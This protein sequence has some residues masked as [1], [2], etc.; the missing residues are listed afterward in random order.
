[1]INIIVGLIIIIFIYIYFIKNLISGKTKNDSDNFFNLPSSIKKSI[2]IF[3]QLIYLDIKSSIK[4]SFD[5]VIKPN[6]EF[7]L[8]HWSGKRPPHY[9]LLKN[10][11]GEFVNWFIACR[12]R[13][14][15]LKEV[16]K[17]VLLKSFKQTQYQR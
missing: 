8:T 15:F 10:K 17:N 16:I 3:N 12:P 1:M 7:I 14:P 5:E 13:H 4:T 2:D 9:K 11:K 6:D